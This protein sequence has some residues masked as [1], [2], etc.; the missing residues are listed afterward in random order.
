MLS[1]RARHRRASASPDGNVPFPAQQLFVLALC[2]IAEPIA[3]MSIFPYIYY[4]VSSFNITTDEKQIAMYAGMVTS[5]F[6]FAEFMTGVMWGRLSDRFG[7]KPILLT[8]LAGTGLSMLLFGLAPNLPVALLARALGGLLNGNIGVLQTTVAEV[9]TVESQQPRAYSIMPFVWCL[10]SIIGSGLGGTL[11]EPAKGY[12]SVFLPGSLFDRFPYL[13][14][15][16]VC[17]TVVLCGLVIGLLFLE[18]TH[19]DKK[20]RFD[21]GLECGKWILRKLRGRPDDMALAA[22][23]GYIE[24]TC[25]LLAEDSEDEQP[26]GYH[27]TEGSPLLEASRFQAANASSI[28]S[29]PPRRSP[30][31]KPSMR[32]AFTPQVILNIVGY[33]ILAF[34]TISFEQLLPVLMSMPESHEPA[35]LPFRFVGGFALPA[36]TIGFILSFQGFMQMIVQVFIF[37]VISRRFGSL[38]TFRAVIFAYPF[39]YAMTP[40]L[41]LLPTS[42]RMAGVLLVL[43]WKVTAQSLSYPSN[44]IMLANSAPSKKVLGTLNGVAASSASLCRAFGPTVSGLIQSA[45]LSLGYSGLSWWACA[46]VA[47][48]GATESLFMREVKTRFEKVESSEYETDEESG[49]A[50]LDPNALSA[51]YIAA[52]GNPVQGQTLHEGVEEDHSGASKEQY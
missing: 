6:A 41:T 44:A 23:A 18:E 28:R 1:C 8:G 7:R 5:A 46:L 13:L 29:P 36:K 30:Q 14:P 27:S 48:V 47:T 25:Y 16:L 37:P 50:L 19:E 42:M 35:H 24:Q 22:K 34:H 15:N 32:S 45:G 38:T 21:P 20:D 43:F 9:V 4:M 12:P 17:T 11:A 2:R 51:S 26:P 33:G 40:Y 49:E 31:P 39:L 10:G 3:F 52:D